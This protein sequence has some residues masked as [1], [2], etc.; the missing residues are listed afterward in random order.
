[1]ADAVACP[2]IESGQIARVKTQQ[3]A[4]EDWKVVIHA[5]HSAYISWEEYERKF[6]ATDAQSYRWNV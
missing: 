4:P 5:S 3:L 1:M 6:R 2:G